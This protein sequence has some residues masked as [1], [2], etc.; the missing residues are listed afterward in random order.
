[1]KT[2]NIPDE[3]YNK[4]MELSKEYATQNTRGTAYPIYFSIRQTKRFNVDQNYSGDT[5]WLIGDDYNGYDTK[6]E[7][8]EAIKDYIEE[9]DYKNI[10]FTDA[11]E[12]DKFL[13]NNN[14]HEVDYQN[15]EV[16]SGAFLT[17]KACDQHIKANHY[18]YSDDAC[19]YGEHGWR[20]PD[21]EIIS[22]LLQHLGK[23]NK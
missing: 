12:V 19:S 6:E 15:V 11:Y 7:A 20:N 4:L 9:D 2:I 18:H 5:C 17:A 13:E 16:F 10:D 14:A 3:L 21:M 22:D 23:V 1:M 8:I